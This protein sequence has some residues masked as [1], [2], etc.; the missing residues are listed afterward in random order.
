MSKNMQAISSQVYLF[1][2]INIVKQTVQQ[3]SKHD[4][5]TII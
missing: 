2:E 4:N 3:N 1:G 5:A